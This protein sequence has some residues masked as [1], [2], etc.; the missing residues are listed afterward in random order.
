M[1]LVNKIQGTRS[2][3]TIDDFKSVIGRRSGLSPTNRF[4]IFMNP[5]S[6][7]LLNLDLQNPSTNLKSQNFGPGKFSNEPRDISILCESCSLP[8]RQIQTLDKQHLN[9]RQSIKNPQ[10]YFNEDVNFV[11]HLTNDYHMK[12][13]FDRW[14]DLI[15]NPET[16]Q[17]GYKKEYVTDVTIQQLNQQNVPVYGVKLK[18]AF[19]VTVNTIEL[20]NASAETQKLNVTL[21]YEDY[22]TE[23]SIASSIGRNNKNVIGGE[24]PHEK[25][26]KKIASL[27]ANNRLI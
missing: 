18:N 11:F 15:V 27:Q 9:Y 17:V 2:T 20:N 3:T 16:Y 21:T 23:G 26:M 24:T 5:P 25:N 10:G 14:L 4:A 6:Q 1:S 13:L 12:K 22:E 8:G 19:P 7:T